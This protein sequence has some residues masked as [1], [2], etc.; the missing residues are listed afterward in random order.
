MRT[1]ETVLGVIRQRGERG[2]PLDDLYRQLF[3][4]DLYLAAYARLYANQG[5]LT[6]GSTPDTVDGMSLAKITALIADLRD[7]RYRWTPV[8]RTYIPKKNGK[9]RPLGL[10]M[11]PSYCT[12]MQGVWGWPHGR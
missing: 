12:S 9:L 2:L 8:R 1:A 6:P 4:P 11:C 7:E 5:A 10:P 3:N